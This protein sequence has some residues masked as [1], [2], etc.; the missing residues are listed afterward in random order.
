[1]ESGCLDGMLLGEET[2]EALVAYHPRLFFKETH[3]AA[4]LGG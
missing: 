3:S 1:M 2:L 4:R